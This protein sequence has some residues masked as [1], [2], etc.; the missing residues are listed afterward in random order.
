M[1][2]QSFSFALIVLSFIAVANADICRRCTSR[3][4]QCLIDQDCLNACDWNERSPKYGLNGDC[5]WG[6]CCCGADC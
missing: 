2:I 3:R 6:R 5:D 4:G 1:K